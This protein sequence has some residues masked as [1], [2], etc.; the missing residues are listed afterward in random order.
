MRLLT[1]DVRPAHHD[2]G[3]NGYFVA[4]V[5]TFNK[6]GYDECVAK[7]E[8]ELVCF[9]LNNNSWRYNYENYHGPFPFYLMAISVMLFGENIFAMRIV[10]AILGVLIGLFV[11]LFRK[12]LGN[13]GSLAAC[14]FLLFSPAL[15]YYSLDAIHEYYF[16]FFA[17][18]SLCFFL[19]FAEKFEGKYLYAGT[20]M[21]AFL[22]TTKEASFLVGIAIVV[23]SLF[24]FLFNACNKRVCLNFNI[25]KRLVISALLCF[26][27]FSFVFVTLFSSLFTNMK[28]AFDAF[29][30]PLVWSERMSEGAGHEKPQSYYFE[31]MLFSESIMLF[32]A[33]LG[34]LI[35]FYRGNLTLLSFSAFFL[36]FIVGASIPK[37][38]V[39]WGLITALP[40]LALLA[41]YAIEETYMLLLKKFD[42][43]NKRLF[44]IVFILAI[45]IILLFV[46]LQ[47]FYLNTE[48]CE[49][50]ENKLV[51]VQT[52]FSTKNLLKRIESLG[53][54]DLKIAVINTESVWPLPWLIKRYNTTYYDGNTLAYIGIDPY[55]V[56][57]VEIAY[58]YKILGKDGFYKETISLRPGMEMFAYLKKGVFE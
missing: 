3:V 12:Q 9:I 7:K 49:S 13:F 31:L 54:A 39:P 18:A 1:I 46:F 48:K 53:K 26:I 14:F 40:P 6:S 32:I 43:A 2:E 24:L 8:N 16:A 37:Y 11:L 15:L 10:S 17:F 4:Q 35:A 41:G 19:K 20:L 30:S 58:D 33:V 57:L 21:L 34:I 28:G 56:A 51:Y 50:E 25:Y 45:S 5:L 38:K 23:I 27:I 29:K 47:S 55:D 22:F 52:K 36:L 42:K 44:S